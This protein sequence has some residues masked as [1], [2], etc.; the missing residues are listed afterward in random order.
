VFNLI[1][2]KLMMTNFRYFLHKQLLLNLSVLILLVLSCK[3]D[4]NGAANDKYTIYTAGFIWNN[5]NFPCYWKGTSRTDLP[6]GT[7]AFTTSIFVSEGTVYTAGYYYNSRGG[8]APCYWKGTTKVNLPYD[9]TKSDYTTSIF[10]LNGAVYTAGHS[11]YWVNSVR[12]ALEDS[13]YGAFISSIYVMD[14]TVYLAGY[15]SGQMGNSIPCYWIG[16]K[17]TDLPVGNS[18]NGRASSMYVSNGTVY[19]CGY[20]GDRGNS[21]ACY[22]KGTIKTDL[23]DGGNASYIT[24]DGGTVYTAGTNTT[25]KPCYW[26]GT[27]KTDLVFK[28]YSSY[29]IDV[30]SFCVR[31]GIVF[32]AGRYYKPDP[33]NMTDVVAVP[34]YWIG[35]SRTDLPVIAEHEHNSTTS[36]FVE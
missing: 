1:E 6:G 14:T 11:C 8:Q 22:W 5:G 33:N 30:A 18:A 25:G 15:R 13:I 20:D 27:L 34:C 26:K 32:T 16:N 17:R 2:K 28:G 10:V 23:P 29:G 7:G 24:M 12:K 19:T 31:G 36:I 4:D 9:S 35:N 21:I 3:K